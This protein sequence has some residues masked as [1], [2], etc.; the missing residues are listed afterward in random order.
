MCG[1]V[2]KKLKEDFSGTTS[3]SKMVIKLHLERVFNSVCALVILCLGATKLRK[4]D[5]FPSST[6]WRFT[7]KS[8]LIVQA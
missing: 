4:A 3:V 8:T 1:P 2:L 5:M 6:Q 7:R